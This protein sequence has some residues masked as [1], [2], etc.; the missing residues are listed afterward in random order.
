MLQNR[1][2]SEFSDVPS[3]GLSTDFSKPTPGFEPGTSSLRVPR[4]QGFWTTGGTM[5]TAEM[6]SVA[7]GIAHFGSLLCQA[8]R[9]GDECFAANVI[10][11]LPSG[12]G[13][14]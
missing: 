11:V 6:L 9:P 8:D 1:L 14:V 12:S 5:S 7:L 13:F 3:R 2:I 4:F 10:S